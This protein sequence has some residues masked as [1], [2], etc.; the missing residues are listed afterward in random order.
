METKNLNKVKDFLSSEAYEA[1]KSG[2]GDNPVGGNE[3]LSIGDVIKV[4]KFGFR[5]NVF[6]SPKTG[7][8]DDDFNS[9]PDDQ[10]IKAGG[11]TAEWFTFESSF[12]SH[13]IANILRP[14]KDVDW[15]NDTPTSGYTP[16][17]RRVSEWLLTQDAADLIGGKKTLT[18]INKGTR[19]TR[20]GEQTHYLFEL[21]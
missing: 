12:G 16:T 6:N 19:T 17:T 20:L 4:T 21:K 9:L 8:S 15:D 10:K 11:R 3:T 18:V 7:M 2:K 13:S 14:H 1:L 5:S